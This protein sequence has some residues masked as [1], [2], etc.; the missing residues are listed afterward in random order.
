M[1][2][3][4]GTKYPTG[5]FQILRIDVNPDNLYVNM[6]AILTA[7]VYNPNN[8]VLHYK[9]EVSGGTL[10]GTGYQVQWHTPSSSGDYLI[11]LGVIGQSGEDY[12]RLFV[13]VNDVL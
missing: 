7:Q 12:E 1:L 4:A 6:D 5:D 10:Y 3:C 2:S 11:E 13:S 9:W 8:E